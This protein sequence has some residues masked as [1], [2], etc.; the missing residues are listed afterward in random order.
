MRRLKILAK[1]ALFKPIVNFIIGYLCRNA[2][3]TCVLRRLWLTQSRDC[4]ET[5]RPSAIEATAK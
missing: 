1:F 5:K 4:S 3:N 2:G